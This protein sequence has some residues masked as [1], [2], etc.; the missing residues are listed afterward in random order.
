M[1]RKRGP[2]SGGAE[3]QQRDVALVLCDVLSHSAASL[4]IASRLNPIE[5]AKRTGPSP[6]MS[7]STYAHIYDEFEGRGP[8]DLESVIGDARRAA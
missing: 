2:V 5:V 6:S 4:F 3:R 8:I 1:D 7:R